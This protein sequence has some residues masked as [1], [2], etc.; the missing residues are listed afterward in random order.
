LKKDARPVSRR[1]TTKTPGKSGFDHK[2]F[3]RKMYSP[4]TPNMYHKRMRRSYDKVSNFLK[5][6]RKGIKTAIEASVAAAALM[7][8]GAEVAGLLRAGK[9]AEAAALNQ[10]GM[11]TIVFSN[12]EATPV[13][14][15]M[16]S[17]LAKAAKYEKESAKALVLAKDVAENVYTQGYEYFEMES[18]IQTGPGVTG[19]NRSL[20]AIRRELGPFSPDRE[21]TMLSAAKGLRSASVRARRGVV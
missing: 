9:I 20:D 7:A 13:G 5:K 12:G 3:I 10:A 14:K 1:R 4:V 19:V 2:A 15:I 21:R 16:D 6:H 11:D 8:G 17:V 18:P